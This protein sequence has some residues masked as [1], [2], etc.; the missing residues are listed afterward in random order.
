FAGIGSGLAARLDGARPGE[1]RGWMPGPE[2][3]ILAIAGLAMLQV[4]AGPW[5][6]GA[7][8]AVPRPVL[9]AAMIAPLACAMGLPFPLVMARLRAA[10]PVLVPWAWGVNGCASVVAAVAAG[11]LAMSLGTRSLML[12]GVL[13]YLL[14]AQTQRAIPRGGGGDPYIA[15]ESGRDC[16]ARQVLAARAESRLRAARP[17]GDPLW[18][19]AST[20]TGYSAPQSGWD[21][22]A[23]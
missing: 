12:L 15:P 22:D 23:L 11:L 7:L 16:G 3:I 13:S 10:A 21:C 17:S 4:F 2:H 8:D 20:G 5:L 6:F 19:R 1:R 18:Q 9:A 14:A